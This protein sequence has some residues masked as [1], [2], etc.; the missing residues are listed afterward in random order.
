MLIR[1]YCRLKCAEEGGLEALIGLCRHSED[2]LQV[3][4]ENQSQKNARIHS[5]LMQ[6]NLCG[7]HFL[8]HTYIY[9]YVHTHNLNRR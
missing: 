1:L 5:C 8:L 7:D 3:S 9:T 2:Q 6:I 4:E